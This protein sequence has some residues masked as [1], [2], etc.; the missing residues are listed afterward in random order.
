MYVGGA[1]HKMKPV[2]LENVHEDS[3]FLQASE[4]SPRVDT[5]DASPSE[6]LDIGYDL[7]MDDELLRLG[8]ISTEDR[9]NLFSTDAEVFMQARARSTEGI[10]RE[11]G[12]PAFMAEFVDIEKQ[13]D[14][15]EYCR[16][17]LNDGLDHD[18]QDLPSRRNRYKEVQQKI[19]ANLQ[20]DSKKLAQFEDAQRMWA[21]EMR[22][23]ADVAYE[24]KS[25]DE[26][27]SGPGLETF[28]P[29]YTRERALG[30]TVIYSE[31]KDW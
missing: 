28:R 31:V 18:T 7:A 22:E 10:F 21:D 29:G 12:L 15:R 16:T 27:S 24:D 30:S 3:V 20:N 2:E 8:R 6:T 9:Q 4:P 25:A 17:K 19:E 5:L 26:Q 14:I 11:L 13:T 1:G 23:F